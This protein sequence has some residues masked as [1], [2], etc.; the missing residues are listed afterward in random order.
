MADSV[1]LAGEGQLRALRYCRGAACTAEQDAND[2]C[3][4]Q[5]DCSDVSAQHHWIVVWV[6]FGIDSA[7]DCVQA[8]LGLSECCTEQVGKRDEYGICP[9]AP[10]GGWPDAC[11]ANKAIG[12]WEPWVLD[13]MGPPSP[14]HVSTTTLV[15]APL[16][17]VSSS[18]HS[19]CSQHTKRPMHRSR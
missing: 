7:A 12:Y 9:P 2:L 19:S 1:N 13:K 11:A 4:I 3:Q 10:A 15:P 8:C 17:S 18:C 14:Q 6:E 16:N 5:E